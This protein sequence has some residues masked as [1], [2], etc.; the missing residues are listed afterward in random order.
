MFKGYFADDEQPIIDELLHIV[1]WRAHDFSVCGWN[2]DARAA[3][4]EIAARNPDLVI[5]DIHMDG[6][7]GLELAEAVNAMNKNIAV[8]FLS[9]YDKFEYAVQAIRLRVVGY[10]TK[11]VKAAELTEVLETVKKSAYEHFGKY[12]A[13]KFSPAAEG[14]ADVSDAVAEIV[15]EI[16]FHPEKKHSLAEYAKKYSFNP[17]Y[18]S[19]LFK[20]TIGKSFMEYLM[21]TRLDKAKSLI[22]C[23]GETI[24]EISYLVGF[25]DYYHFS[26]IFKKHVG[27]SPQDYRNKYST[28]K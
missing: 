27:L 19:Q 23:A 24:R 11:P 25:E 22:V 15:D 2:T 20:K 10:L 26:K 3:I 8:C 12:L 1:D 7:S 21:E 13:E 5:A 28:H 9:A 4:G 17:S 14:A 16:A 6:V 18:L